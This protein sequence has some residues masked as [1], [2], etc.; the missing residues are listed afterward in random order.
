MSSTSIISVLLCTRNNRNTLPMVI[1]SYL[2]QDYPNLELIAVIDGEDTTY[3]LFKDVPNLVAP[4]MEHSV[5]N[6]AI[7]RNIGI[8]AAHGDIIVHFDS[9][10]WSGAGRV[11]HQVEAMAGV[12]VVSYSKA[13]WYDI[14]RQLATYADCGP[15]SAS[16]CYER[17][18]ALEHPWDETRLT[19]EDGWFLEPV[20]ES[21]MLRELDGGDN[22]VALS[23]GG[24]LPRPFGEPGWEIVP[25]R[26][27][28]EEFRKVMGLEYD[29]Q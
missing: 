16:M 22:F 9:D 23:H 12:K 14:R 26:H 21:G 17:A 27:L 19:C 4:Y 24:N 5:A 25:N 18:W 15:W 6:L 7:K 8:R 2:S 3:E 28:P 10:D 13:W 20:R 1:E 11:R 29:V